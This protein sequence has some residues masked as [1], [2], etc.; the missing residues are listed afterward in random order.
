MDTGLPRLE[1]EAHGRIAS[2][3]AKTRENRAS[4]DKNQ[5]NSAFQAPFYRPGRF[6]TDRLLARLP[7]RQ[8]PRQL[9]TEHIRIEAVL[10]WISGSQ[11]KTLHRFAQPR[12]IETAFPAIQNGPWLRARLKKLPIDQRRIRAV[13]PIRVSGR[14]CPY[15]ERTGFLSM[16]V[17]VRLLQRSATQSALVP[18]PEAAQGRPTQ[19]R[20]IGARAE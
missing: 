20:H 11:L 12:S 16:T 4:Y 5:R 7:V 17:A 10:N 3:V 18:V 6:K 13:W 19:I 8:S 2:A 1:F 14:R 15:D 9:A